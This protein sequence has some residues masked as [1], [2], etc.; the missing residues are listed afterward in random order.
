MPELVYFLCALTSV[1][2]ATLLFRS[3]QR[4]RLRLL[5]WSSACFTAL[6]ATNVLLFVD[7]A[8][9]PRSDLSL[10]RT[11]LTLVGLLLLLY[12]LITES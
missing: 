2:C 8:V 5:L 1:V 6:A 9:A 12:G 7:L 11:A 3:Y 10:Y 4:T